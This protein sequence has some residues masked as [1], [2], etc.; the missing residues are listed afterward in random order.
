MSH[1][2]LTPKSRSSLRGA[3]LPQWFPWAVAAGSVAAGLGI[4]TAAGLN[5]SIQWALIAVVLF[6]GGTYAI[7]ARVEG[8]GRPRT[9]W[10]PARSGS[11]SCWP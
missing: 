4:S 5:S 7:S 3:T 9:G 2:T 6:V 11:R 10:R 8:A 1:A